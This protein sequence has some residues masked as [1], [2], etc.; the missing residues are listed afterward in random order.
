MQCPL[1]Y[2]E[3]ID[4]WM[5]H[6][7]GDRMNPVSCIDCDYCYDETSFSGDN[8]VEIRYYC[9]RKSVMIPIYDPEESRYCADFKPFI[10]DI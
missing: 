2:Q 3:R 7:Q 9:Q 1:P 8:Y 4:H 5:R 6:L 10:E